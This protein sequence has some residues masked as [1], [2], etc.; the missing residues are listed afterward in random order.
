MRIAIFTD[1]FLPQINGVV[2]YV[3]DTATQLQRRGHQVIIFAPKPRR[4]VKLNLEQYPFS[5][6]LLPSLP[7]FIYPD[8][9]FTIPSLP[10]VLLILKRFKPDV[11]HIQD[12][13][14][15]GTEGLTAGKILKI[16]VAITF[17]TFFL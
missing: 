4:G 3:F 9:R 17:H 12:P 10:K 16:P 6:K 2:S 13:S 15:V 11:I 8:I 14:T 7:S 1:S 5:I